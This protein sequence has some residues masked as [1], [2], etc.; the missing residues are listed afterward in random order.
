MASSHSIHTIV[1]FHF[2]VSKTHN[3]V[4]TVSRLS[5]PTDESP[6]SVPS[7]SL[8]L[9]VTNLNKAFLQKF[10]NYAPPTF[11]G[12]KVAKGQRANV[13]YVRTITLCDPF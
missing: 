6:L 1:A 7:H 4:I 9:F 2:H 3:N 12:I 8:G 13:T 5:S 10:Q 11:R